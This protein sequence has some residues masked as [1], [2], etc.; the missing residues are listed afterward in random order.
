[1]PQLSL[2][3]NVQHCSQYPYT[4]QSKKCYFLKILKLYIFRIDI[5]GGAVWSSL[6]QK[7][8]DH[9]YNLS[10]LLQ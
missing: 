5:L 3:G 7:V 10:Q 4:L 6:V 2:L 1:M 8:Q 9:L